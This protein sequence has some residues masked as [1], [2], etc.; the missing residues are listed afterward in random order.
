MY[1][2]MRRRTSHGL[3]AASISTPKHVESR[4]NY[5]TSYKDGS[6]VTKGNTT[7]YDLWHWRLVHALRPEITQ[8]FTSGIY[9]MRSTTRK[10]SQ[11]C[12][13]CLDTEQMKK[14]K[15]GKLANGSQNVTVDADI[16]GP[17]Q[18]PLFIGMRYF[19]T[20][21]AVRQRCVRI[22]PLCTGTEIEERYLIY[23]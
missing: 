13:T 15:N 23:V 17:H 6:G 8:M 1:G 16:S 9:G 3:Y 21:T 11:S 5:A 2:I 10:E 18:K 20:L 19:L 14:S 7:A 4:I 22:Q 12:T